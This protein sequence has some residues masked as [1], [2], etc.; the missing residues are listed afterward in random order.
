MSKYHTTCILLNFK[1]LVNYLLALQAEM[2]FC[3]DI[4]FHEKNP[5]PG[6]K[7]FPRY[8][9]DNKFRIRGIK[10]SRLIKIPNPGD[11]NPETQKFR[12]FR[13]FSIQLKIKNPDPGDLGSR[14][15]PSLSQLCLRVKSLHNNFLRYVTPSMMEEV[16]A[17]SMP[18]GVPA[19]LDS[20]KSYDLVQ[21]LV[22]NTF[23]IPDNDNE[24][25][26]PWAGINVLRNGKVKFLF[27]A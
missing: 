20:E 10:I 12:D 15:I 3:P 9:E 19:I 5:D 21:Q 8:P 7:K 11:K 1:K 24:R 4:P 16:C 27:E 25:E 14:K 23:G 13:D 6:D 22:K 18:N 17:A 2:A 26:G